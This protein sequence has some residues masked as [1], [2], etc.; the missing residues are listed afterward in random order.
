MK[1]TI[2]IAVALALAALTTQALA[3]T[4]Q[5]VAPMGPDGIV[6]DA[7][8]QLDPPPRWDARKHKW[9]CK[10]YRQ[11]NCTGKEDK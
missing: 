6:V 7:P 1:R 3:Q 4:T 11:S 5:P 2:T 9:I 8:H 10:G